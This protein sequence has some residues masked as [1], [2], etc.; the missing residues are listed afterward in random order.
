MLDQRRVD[1]GGIV[2][3]G[4]DAAGQR[5]GLA[6]LL[7]DDPRVMEAPRTRDDLIMPVLALWT[8]QQ[9]LDDAALAHA[10]QH[11]GHVRCLFSVAHV[12]PADGTLVLVDENECHG[13]TLCE[14]RS[15]SDKHTSE[16]Q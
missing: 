13:T 11:I 6:R 9:R 15:R 4:E 16:L 5:V 8:H 3:Y 2:G 10:W 7:R 1:G 14:G 12:G